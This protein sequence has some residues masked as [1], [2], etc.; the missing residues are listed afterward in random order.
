MVARQ[1]PCVQGLVWPKTADCW[2]VYCVGRK[3]ALPLLAAPLL[4]HILH[5]RR[6]M[7]QKGELH[8][9]AGKAGKEETE[10]DAF[11]EN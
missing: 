11:G 6:Y 8:G 5:A 9:N 3:S 7:T 1:A 10:C 2:W 4:R